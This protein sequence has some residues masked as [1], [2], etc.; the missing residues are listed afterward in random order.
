VNV[1]AEFDR[2]I[3]AS[4]SPRE[5]RLQRA[6]TEALAQRLRRSPTWKKTQGRSI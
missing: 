4:Y 3:R 1:K 5:L 2:I 6:L